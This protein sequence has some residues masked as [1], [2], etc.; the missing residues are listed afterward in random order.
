[1]FA[2]LFEANSGTEIKRFSFKMY[3]F[4]NKPVQTAC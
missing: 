4:I 3:N 1:M 2:I